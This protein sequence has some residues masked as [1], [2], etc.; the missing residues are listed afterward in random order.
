MVGE[1]KGVIAI[2]AKGIYA[3]GFPVV[4]EIEEFEGFVKVKGIEDEDEDGNFTG[5]H[6]VDVFEGFVDTGAVF[7]IV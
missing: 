5:L 3:G 4:E 1:A 7:L 6:V 2:V